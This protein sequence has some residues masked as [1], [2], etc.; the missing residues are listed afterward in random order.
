M[1]ERTYVDSVM[2]STTCDLSINDY[3]WSGFRE[4]LTSGIKTVIYTTYKHKKISAI[5]SLTIPLA[6]RHPCMSPISITNV[7]ITKLL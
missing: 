4:K 1:P 5:G 2:H 7:G 6:V 3:L